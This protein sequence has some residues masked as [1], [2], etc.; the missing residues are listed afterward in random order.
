[1]WIPCDLTIKLSIGFVMVELNPVFIEKSLEINS[2]T[3]LTPSNL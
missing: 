3:S 1:M 2:K